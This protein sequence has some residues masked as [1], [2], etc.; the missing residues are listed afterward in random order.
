[1]PVS[2]K[3]RIGYNTDELD[4][5]LPELLAEEP[6]AITVHARTRKEMYDVPARWDTVARAV[7]LRDKSGSKT[8]IL[9]NGGCKGH[10]RCALRRQRQSA[11]D[12][13]GRA[14][15]GNPWLFAG[16]RAANFARERVRALTEH[17]VLFDELALGHNELCGYENTFKAYISG[18]DGAKNCG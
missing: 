13:L 5:W 6:A 2:V 1:M 14:I 4:S 3:T 11:T 10:S 18:W 8:L 9:G 12:M 7:R 16:A 15:Y 17:L